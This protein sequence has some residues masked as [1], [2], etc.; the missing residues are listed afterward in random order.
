MQRKAVSPSWKNVNQV[1]GGNETSRHPDLKAPVIAI[2]A[3][4]LCLDFYSGGRL[5][6][7][8]QGVR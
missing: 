1:L 6:R 4:S 8:A 3:F 2:D 5:C 7:P